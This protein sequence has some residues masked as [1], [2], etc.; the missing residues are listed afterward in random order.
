MNLLFDGRTHFAGNGKTG[1]RWPI[2][3]QLSRHGAVVFGWHQDHDALA[4]ELHQVA[5][6]ARIID[7]S[8][9]AV[10]VSRSVLPFGYHTVFLARGSEVEVPVELM[11]DALAA[12]ANM[13]AT[14]RPVFARRHP[15]SDLA[16]LTAFL[17]QPVR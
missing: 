4:N 3:E 7:L 6:A 13:T 16:S 8:Y 12:L 2:A 9:A 1:I 17:I 14:H 5:T 15:F 10:R 11:D